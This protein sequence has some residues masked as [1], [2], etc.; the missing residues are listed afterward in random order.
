MHLQ[1]LQ[2]AA[3]AKGQSIAA[4]VVKPGTTSFAGC[5][6]STAVPRLVRSHD[7]SDV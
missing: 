1:E 5:G 4:E 3:L 6:V 2:A 7:S